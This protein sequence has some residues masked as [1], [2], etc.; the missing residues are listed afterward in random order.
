MKLSTRSTYGLRALLGLAMSYGSAPVMIKELAEKQHLPET[1]L[2]QLMV[3]LRK[4]GVV[5][6]TRGR[7]GGYT[8]ARPPIEITIADVV[9]VFEGAIDL[10][11]CSTVASCCWQ[12]ET[13]ALK[14]LLEEASEALL[15]VFRRTT[16]ANLAERQR[17]KESMTVLTYDI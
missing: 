9:E 13:C 16:L 7:R 10:V 15:A 11:E 3:P 1:Y 2:E 5:L 12:P 6:A 14:D 17:E 4:A 8:L